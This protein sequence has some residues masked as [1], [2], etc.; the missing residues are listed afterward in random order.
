[1]RKKRKYTRRPMTDDRII[2]TIT[3]IRTKN[4]KAWMNM[5]RLA[6]A[7]KP[8]QAAKIMNQIVEND[9]LVTKWMEKLGR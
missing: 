6:F 7:S 2:K 1:M 5:L 3:S 4:N 9:K 8:R